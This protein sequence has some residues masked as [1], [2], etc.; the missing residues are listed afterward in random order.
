MDDRD[1]GNFVA[2]FVAGEGCFYVSVSHKLIGRTQVDC[3]FSIRLRNDDRELL[4][5]IHR[6]LKYSGNIYDIPGYI[7][8]PTRDHT[9][10]NDAVYLLIRNI[11]EL[12]NY[13]IPFFDRY[14]LHGRKRRNYEIWKEAV[15]I[16]ACGEH[17]TPEG[18]DRVIA[19]KA[20][21]NQYQPEGADYEQL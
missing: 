19:I 12:L 15:A 9:K 6:T 8:R 14:Q 16:L 5:A 11:D 1:F 17:T 20:R 21:L 10:R 13:V 3:G 2:G 7:S 4:Q 18:L